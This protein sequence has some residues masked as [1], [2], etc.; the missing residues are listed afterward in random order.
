[1]T[2]NPFPNCTSFVCQNLL[3]VTG[4]YTIKIECQCSNVFKPKFSHFDHVTSKAPYINGTNTKFNSN[5]LCFQYKILSHLDHVTNISQYS[6][7]YPHKK[8]NCSVSQK[9]DHMV[10][11]TNTSQPSIYLVRESR[12]GEYITVHY[13]LAFRVNVS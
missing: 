4:T 3:H 10:R 9:H 6:S 1:M 2:S 8:K 7:H 11:L 5:V 13:C 12:Q